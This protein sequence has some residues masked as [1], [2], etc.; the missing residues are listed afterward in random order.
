M[1]AGRDVE[2]GEEYQTGP[3]NTA[4]KLIIILVMNVRMR[5]IWRARLL[6]HITSIQGAITYYCE[7]CDFKEYR[8]GNFKIH[9]KSIR[10]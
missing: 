3:F 1:K 4:L 2:L 7:Q 10:F 5:W 9:I 8:K 6:E